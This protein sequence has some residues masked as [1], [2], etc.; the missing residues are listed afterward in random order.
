M[1]RLFFAKAIY[2]DLDLVWWI[3]FILIVVWYVE[4]FLALHICILFEFVKPNV[5]LISIFI[6]EIYK[7]VKKK[8][9]ICVCMFLI[10]IRYFAV[11]NKGWIA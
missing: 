1:K 9:T 5:G 11:E 3:Q 2:L 7:I 4:I 6:I 8:I 10:H